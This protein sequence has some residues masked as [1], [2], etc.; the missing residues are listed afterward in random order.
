MKRLFNYRI[1]PLVLLGIILAICVVTYFDFAMRMAC[2]AGALILLLCAIFI[3]Q[4]KKARGKLIAV[5]L[6]FCIMTGI[7][8]LDFKTI[9]DRQIY[10]RDAVI[11]GRIDIA[12]E[13]NPEGVLESQGRTEIYLE[14]ITVNGVEYSGRAQTVF[15]DG[16]L[17]YGLKVGD[18]IKFRGD[19]SPLTPDVDDTYSI[20]D[21]TDGIYYYIYAA[22]FD[23]GEDLLFECTGNDATV[24][25]KIKL[26]VKSVLYKNVKSETAGF[27]YAMT[28]GDKAQLTYEIKDS[29]SY[30]GTAHIFAVSGLHIGIIAGAAMLI[31][32]RLKIKNDIAV[33]CIIS[34][35]LLPFCALC[36]FSPSTVRATLMI[37][38][39]LVAKIAMMRSDAM[40]NF[41]A[42]GCILLV[43][44]P[45]F[46]FDLGFLM[47]FAAV[48][49]LITLS[50]PLTRI[51]MKIKTPKPLANALGASLS[52]NMAL[53]PVMLVYFGGQSLLFIIANLIVIPCI[54]LIFPIYLFAVFLTAIVSFTGFLLTLA[55][56]PFT[57]L[58]YIIKQIGGISFLSVDFDIS[59]IF[60]AVNFVV[61]LV[62][63]EYVFI[64]QKAKKIT[65]GVLFA[66]LCTGMVFNLNLRSADET[67]IFGFTDKSGCQLMIIDDKTRGSYLIVNG[68]TDYTAP[69]LVTDMMRE[70]HI[71]QIDGV[72]VVGD[73][74][75]ESLSDIMYA[76]KSTCIYSFSLTDYM[77]SG[78]ET[79]TVET[80]KDYMLGFYYKGLM[81]I[82]IDGIE[83]KVL[84]DGYTLSQAD[85]EYDILVCYDN[86]GMLDEGKYAVCQEGYVNSLQNY[87]SSTFTIRI[88]DD[89][90]KA[91][92]FWS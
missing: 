42:A 19:V 92:G 87:M 81:E 39:S 32:R 6:A 20:A 24:A 71:S 78:Y 75:E 65:A 70:K 26:K 28:F 90:I 85:N 48:F 2:I 23:E 68:Q 36:E 91:N 58:I 1:I 45:L 50:K 84:A 31:L 47:S 67:Y 57:V 41:S 76:A 72:F 46:L 73:C 60:I 64:P 77:Y 34:T 4:M 43:A 56:A 54:S 38:I 40:T 3:K 21:Y 30:T 49:G 51:F 22:C 83:I 18:R 5:L 27:L 61:M 16:S 8:A 79:D 52:V 59:R 86:V 29:F 17:L 89:K 11:E 63:S 7:T 74:D 35:L 12:S 44:N 25:D 80:G 82:I 88:K 55:G 69:G 13:S 9:D 14:D 15:I 53:M 10:A 37:L 33:F 62:L 66:A